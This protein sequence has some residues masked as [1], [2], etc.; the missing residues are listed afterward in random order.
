MTIPLW[1]DVCCWDDISYDDDEYT[2]KNKH[3]GKTWNQSCM[4]KDG[5][6]NE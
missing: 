3:E 1:D 5:D 6:K 2:P 4:A